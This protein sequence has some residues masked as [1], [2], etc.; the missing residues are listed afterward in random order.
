MHSVVPRDM[1][2]TS[3]SLGSKQALSCMNNS[4]KKFVASR[5]DSGMCKLRVYRELKEDFECKKY[6]Y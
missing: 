1:D 5:L 2:L 3:S 4:F 6:L